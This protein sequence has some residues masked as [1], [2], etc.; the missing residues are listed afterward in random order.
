MDPMDP[1]PPTDLIHPMAP[2]PPTHPMD[3]MDPTRLMD[4]TDLTDPTDPMHLMPRITILLV[5]SGYFREKTSLLRS[6]FVQ[7]II[8]LMKRAP[9]VSI[10]W[11]CNMDCSYCLAESNNNHKAL[12][13]VSDAK[14]LFNWLMSRGVETIALLGGEPTIHPHFNEITDIIRDCGIKAGVATN[15]LF[16]SEKRGAFER[17]VYKRVSVH[18]NDEWFYNSDQIEKLRDNLAFLSQS[19]TEIETRYVAHSSGIDTDFIKEMARISGSKII[20]FSIAR[21][22]VYGGTAYLPIK[23]VRLL[24]SKLKR[25]IDGLRGEG[26][27]SNIIALYPKCIKRGYEDL[28]DGYDGN[29]CSLDDAGQFDVSFMINPDLT[30]GVCL[31][32]P[33]IRTERKVVEFLDL[34]EI[35]ESFKDEFEALRRQPI[36]EDCLSCLDFNVDCQGGCLVYKDFKNGTRK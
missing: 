12:M 4:P 28:F 1:T 33:N 17:E 26:Y 5:A 11:G 20:N 31:S 14:A 29:F 19:G 24:L 36:F 3:P 25:V 27:I 30:A 6:F 22:E 9:M 2:T 8:P 15:G 21:P 16:S 34:E 18:I 23:S 13:S 32:L 35:K 7:N 10:I